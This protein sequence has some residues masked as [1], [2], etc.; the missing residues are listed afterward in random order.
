[1]FLEK[2]HGRVETAL[3]W[4]QSARCHYHRYLV[5]RPSSTYGCHHRFLAWETDI[6][7]D[8]YQGKFL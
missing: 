1:M 8:V 6:Y 3:E 2:G 7:D 5:I 4:E